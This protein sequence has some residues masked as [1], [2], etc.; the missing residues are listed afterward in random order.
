MKRPLFLRTALSVA[1]LSVIAA[2]GTSDPEDTESSEPDEQETA[3][4]ETPEPEPEERD[5]PEETEADGANPEVA[6]LEGTWSGP[7]NED[8]S[9]ASLTFQPN[10]AATLDSGGFVCNGEVDPVDGS[11]FVLTMSECMIPL[12]SVQLEMADDGESFVD[13]DGSEWFREES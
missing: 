11:T 12:P 13:D 1:L 10:G 4:E 5:T 7:K 8:G 3:V 2:C 6:A 9:D